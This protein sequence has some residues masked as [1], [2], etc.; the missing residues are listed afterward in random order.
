[1]K[2]LDRSEF[3][4]LR[5]A[6]DAA[7]V[8]VANEFG[9]HTLLGGK[10]TVDSAAGNFTIKVEGIVKGGMSPEETRLEYHKEHLGIPAD[11]TSGMRFRYANQF[12]FLRGANTTLTKV[13]L[14]G[15]NGKKYVAAVD[16]FVKHASRAI[17]IGTAA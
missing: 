13:L 12:F 8:P 16:K 3:N 5:A 7:L 11:W 10:V 17:D 15:E 2:R 1:M 14:E 6:I 4:K 9:L